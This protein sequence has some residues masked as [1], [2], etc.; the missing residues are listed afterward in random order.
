M[1][2]GIGFAA[3]YPGTPSTEI[4]DSLASVGKKMNFYAEWS[5]NEKVAFETAAGASFA[6]IRAITSMKQNG[7][8]VISDFLANLVLSGIGAGLVLVSCDDPSAISSSNEQDTRNIAKWLDIPL[9]E[10]GT[11]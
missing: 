6:G 8:N 10:P 2:A 1:E 11:F 7:V 5:V 9:L 4:M 3:A